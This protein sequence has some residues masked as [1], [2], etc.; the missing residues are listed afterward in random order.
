MLKRLLG[1]SSL[2]SGHLDQMDLGRLGEDYACKYLLK[3]NYAILKRN[4]RCFLGEIDIIARDRDTVVFVEVKSQYAHVAIQ[5]ER[6]VNKRKQKK[7]LALSRFY[8]LKNLSPATPC[9]IDVLTVRIAPDNKPSE[10]IHYKK[11]V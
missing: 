2:P 9:R 10:I 4:Y 8:R 3:N 5:P 11:I 1:L 6:K 7:L